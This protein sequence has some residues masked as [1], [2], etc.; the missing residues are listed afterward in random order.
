MWCFHLP[1]GG[2]CGL[3]LRMQS[4]PSR[5]AAALPEPRYIGRQSHVLYDR[6]RLPLQGSIKCDLCKDALTKA[7]DWGCGKAGGIISALCLDFAPLCE[8]AL[9]ELC[10]ICETHCDVPTAINYVCT[11]VHLC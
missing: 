5:P 6:V 11:K 1:R 10:H 2:R 9:D 8:A 4:S 3:R 7:Y